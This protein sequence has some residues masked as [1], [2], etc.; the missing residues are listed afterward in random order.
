L[1]VMRLAKPSDAASIAQIHYGSSKQLSTGFFSIAGKFF[2]K[3]YY[4]II[5]DNPYSVVVCVEDE[6]RRI[7]GF[8]SGTL[9]ASAHFANLKNNR[10]RLGLALLPSIVQ[11]PRILV[12]ALSRYRSTELE[13]EGQFVI[14]SGA[15]GEFWVWDA[16]SKDTVWA[17]V[18][19]D[20]HLRI[21]RSL[22]VKTLRFE[23]DAENPDVVAYS[24]KNGA[25]VIDTIALADG[26][27]RYIMEYNLR[28]KYGRSR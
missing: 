1:K 5:L 4:S 6:N 10:I 27:T 16:A 17:G 20:A 23:V 3:Q 21:F 8:A 7:C 13:S 18:L 24:L 14:T 2:L 15:R 9:D 26:R 19:N 25:V 11:K 22:G 12:E 28:V